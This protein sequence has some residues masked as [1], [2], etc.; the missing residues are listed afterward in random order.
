MKIQIRLWVGWGVLMLAFPPSCKVV[1]IVL[2][3][4]YCSIPIGAESL[5]AP[6]K[7]SILLKDFSIYVERAAFA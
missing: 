5:K 4:N 2:S 6:N 3:M 1:N 7:F